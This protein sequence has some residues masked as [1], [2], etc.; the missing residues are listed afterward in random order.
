MNI[1]LNEKD[2]RIVEK[3]NSYL[4]QYQLET[5]RCYEIDTSFKIL[6]NINLI[7]NDDIVIIHLYEDLAGL[8]FAKQIRASHKNSLI[9][10][11]A[12]NESL[13]IKGYK[14]NAFEFISPFINYQDFKEIFDR[15]F[16]LERYEDNKII[17]IKVAKLFLIFNIFI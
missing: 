7:K 12:E 3:L 4:K 9:I 17:S 14:V 15:I 11:V 8:E 16:S 13:A 1:Y 5:G 2:N 10:F 6:F